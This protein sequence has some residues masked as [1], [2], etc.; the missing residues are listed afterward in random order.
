MN[1]SLTLHTQG[2][3]LP[4]SGSYP[5]GSGVK[6]RLLCDGEFSGNSIRGYSSTLKNTWERR[7]GN[8]ETMREL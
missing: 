4:A 6:A 8:N 2:R 7:D 1:A 5:A 3:S